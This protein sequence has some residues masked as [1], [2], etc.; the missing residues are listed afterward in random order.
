ML[1][2]LLKDYYKEYKFSDMGQL[3]A[4]SKAPPMETQESLEGKLVLITG[5]TAGIGQATALRFLR[6]GANLLLINR[7][8][9]KTAALIQELKAS[10]PSDHWNENRVRS[11]Q[12]DF[13]SVEQSV[14]VARQILDMGLEVDVLINNAGLH[15]TQKRITDEGFE[16]VFAV[17]HLA[18]FILSRALL[19][20]MMARGSG[21]IVQVNSQGHRFF[22]LNLDDLDWK[23]RKYQGYMAYG[24]A[25]TAQ[26]LCS[27]E[28]ADMAE[29]TGPSVVV[30][31]PGAVKTAVGSNNGPLYRWFHR[32]IIE[33]GLAPVETS[34]IAL[35]S[36]VAHPEL[37]S[38]NGTYFN[39]TTVEKPAPH[40]LD[41][42][43]GKR[44]WERSNEIAD[45]YSAP[46][47]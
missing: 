14:A 30:M 42:D 19:P 10:V 47:W 9:Q 27:W 36:L 32:V 35:H 1:K 26:L 4:N 28:M 45:N 29:S 21:R 25:K 7:N 13:S 12:A 40:A 38:I 34:A 18:P 43:L 23:R 17:N 24:A 6:Y 20:G 2:Q 3:I 46:A 39:L 41:R 16:T 22:G 33:P 37:K 11:L 31:H 5:A 8:E 15:M 44:I